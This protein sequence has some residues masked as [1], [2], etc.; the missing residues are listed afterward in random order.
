MEALLISSELLLWYGNVVGEVRPDEFL[1]RQA[2]DLDRRFVYVR[3]L[4]FW[5]DSDQRIQA[6]LDQ[7][8]GILRFFLLDAATPHSYTLSLHDALPIF[9]HRGVVEDIG[10]PA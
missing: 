3:D 4:A 1:S 7:T 2:G 9:V 6:G 10:E 5:T 8:A